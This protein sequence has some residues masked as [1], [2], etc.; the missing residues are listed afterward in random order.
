MLTQEAERHVEDVEIRG[1]IIDSLI[2][3]KILDVIT[4]RGGSFRIKRI[5]VGQARHDP[6]NALVEV[7]A[8]SEELLAE[9]LAQIADHGAEPTTAHDCRLESADIDGAFPEGFY[10]TTNQRTEIRLAGHWIEVTDQEMDCGVRVDPAAVT[11][12]CVPMNEVRTGEHYVV[13]HAG[14]RVFPEGRAVD[15]QMFEF[16]GSNVSTEKP[17]AIAITSGLLCLLGIIPGLPKIPF[18][19]LALITG[20]IAYGCPTLGSTGSRRGSGHREPA[21]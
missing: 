2:L 16:M 7:S 5:V 20:A 10:S 8:A 11:A 14:T 3:P 15:R 9:I 19:L 4:S 13:G 21:Q 18:F 17:K 1:H 12:R 6:S